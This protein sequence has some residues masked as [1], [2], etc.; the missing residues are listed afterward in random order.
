MTLLDFCQFLPGHYLENVSP[1]HPVFLEQE[2]KMCGYL[3]HSVGKS[4][5]WEGEEHFFSWS[6][7]A[8]SGGG[9]GFS[10]SSV[11]FCLFYNKSL[12]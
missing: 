10:L 2:K 3:E 1:T 4:G 5:K 12:A 9:L 8:P 11:F 7:T 6:P